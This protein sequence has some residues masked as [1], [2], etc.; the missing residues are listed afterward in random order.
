MLWDQCIR[1]YYVE[2]AWT[3][4]RVNRYTLNTCYTKSAGST[5]VIDILRDLSYAVYGSEG[6]DTLEHT[7]LFPRY[8]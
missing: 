7:A 8:G 5:R 2:A 3:G 6:H 1:R 4:M